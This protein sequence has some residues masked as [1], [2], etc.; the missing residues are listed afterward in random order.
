M[1]LRQIIIGAAI[2]AV[3]L[4]APAFWPRTE[5]ASYPRL[6]NLP[7]PL[8]TSKS[9][10]FFEARIAVDPKPLDLALLGQLH[11]QRGRETGDLAELAKAEV[12]LVAAIDRAPRFGAALQTLASVYFVQHRF[13]EALVTARAAHRLD[14]RLGAFVLIGD[15]LV[16]TGD[17]DEAADTYAAAARDSESPGLSARFAHLD[18][19]HGR[20]ESAIFEMKQAAAAHLR[21]GGHGEEAAWYQVRLGDLN[22]AAGDREEADRRYRAA[23]DLF[24]NYY[25]GLAGRAKVAAVRADYDSAIALY[26]KAAAV[27]PRPELLMALGDLY[28]A[29]GQSGLAAD[30]Y[31]TVE[32]IARLAGGVYDRT[33][34][35]FLAD[36][37]R[38]EEALLLADRGLEIRHD[39]FGHD[40]Q[41][42]ALYRLG[43]YE[44]ARRAIDTA[45]VL[46]TRDPVLLFHAGSISFALGELER[47]ADELTKALDP[48]PRFHPLFGDQ[49]DAMLSEA[50]LA[51]ARP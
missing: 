9:I 20:L 13:D 7:P 22:L 26:E 42:W 12:A 8:V 32:T 1:K 10:A 48:N 29:T 41:A 49:A 38:A 25:A 21:T 18:E 51:K 17:Y 47:A 31:E 33:L 23:L 36:H 3:G 16:A 45:L 15:V 4:G 46:G 14:P 43:R 19:L 2:T 30:R 39:I 37:G 34:A 35:L 11:A 5:D 6:E 24:P 50:T 40:T 27:I 28:T 44:E